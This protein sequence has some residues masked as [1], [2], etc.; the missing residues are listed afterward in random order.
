MAKTLD[1]IRAQVEAIRTAIF[2]APHEVP[3]RIVDVLEALLA[4]APIDPA[5][6]PVVDEPPT[7]EAPAE[8]P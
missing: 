4:A 7:A 8:A 5:P 3:H 2:E 1:E 6:A